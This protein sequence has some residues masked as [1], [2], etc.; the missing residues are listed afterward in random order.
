M[1]ALAIGGW[2]GGSLAPVA[3]EG[4]HGPNSQGR[5]ALPLFM[6]GLAVS[7]GQDPT[8][9]R[10]IMALARTV[11]DLPA[12]DRRRLAERSDGMGK[13][14][15]W[16]SLYPASLSVALAPI[17]TRGWVAFLAVWRW[18]VYVS[19]LIGAACAGAAG[20][21]G[22]LAPLGAALGLALLTWSEL[23]LADNLR[24][25][26]PN[27]VLIGL[28]GVAALLFSRG[29]TVS[30]AA[31]AV[32]GA[33][34]KLGSAVALLPLLTA[35]RWRAAGVAAAVGLAAVGLTCLW[36]PLP[37]LVA[38]TLASARS[39]AG[40]GWGP[41]GSDLQTVRMLMLRG[42]PM[43]L[44]TA[45]L[46]ALLG[47]VVADQPGARAEILSGSLALVLVWMASIGSLE[48]EIYAILQVVA[49]AWLLAGAL[50]GP[51]W[52]W[53]VGFAPIALVPLIWAEAGPLPHVQ[54]A[55]VAVVLWLGVAGRMILAALVV[56]P[57]R[58][59]VGIGLGLLA[60]VGW[61]GWWMLS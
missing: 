52:R 54:A 32:I 5:D 49:C 45:L 15:I 48:H 55:M 58:A 13:G 25:A 31:A 1:L 37:N 57:A 21:A 4:F 12:D 28:A 23:A 6:G 33:L 27:L 2:A 14:S 10:A 22:R 20:V 8:D 19:V 46:P 9:P 61:V 39:A 44:S 29:H 51:G 30:G 16:A 7:R 47:F 18:C 36:V 38:D 11:E 60:A 34:T 26:Q 17:S 41:P 42:Q 43:G 24:M 59:R 50:P 53:R 40:V 35:R 3:T 56:A